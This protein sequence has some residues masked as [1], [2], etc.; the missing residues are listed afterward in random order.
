MVR[1]DGVQVAQKLAILFLLKSAGNNT[2]NKKERKP[3]DSVNKHQNGE[4]KRQNKIFLWPQRA[5][6][7]QVVNKEGKERS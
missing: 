7:C 5:L 4:K 3:E 1:R 2:V 6:L